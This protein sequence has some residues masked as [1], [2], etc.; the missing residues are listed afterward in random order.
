M[1][2][3]HTHTIPVSLEPNN[4]TF[5]WHLQGKE[6]PVGLGLIYFNSIIL[7]Y[8]LSG[9]GNISEPVH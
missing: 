3:T 7:N 4:S 5:T 8:T 1:S 2:H 6:V 9:N